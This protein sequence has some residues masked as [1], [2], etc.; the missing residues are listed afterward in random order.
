VTDILERVYERPWLA[1]YQ[2]AAL[3][4]PERYAVVEASTKSGKTVT[5]MA[6]LVE[7]AALAGMPGRNFWWIA[8]I[9]AQARIAYRR[10]RRGLPPGEVTSNESE[11]T[12][13]LPNGAVLWFKGAENPDS[14]FGEDV[15]A[16]VVDEASRVREE[17]WHA[18]RSTLTATRG[19][20]RL[21]GNV[22][23][24]RNWFYRLAR[25]AESGEPDYHHARI[26]AHDAAAAG[27]LAPD[28]VADAERALPAAVFRELYL[29]EPSD[30]EGN[31]FGI[32]AIRAC[33]TPLS[34]SRPACWGVDL[35]KA[36][37][38]TVAI[39]LDAERRV[40][41]LE[42]FQRSWQDTIRVL[43]D[44]LGAVPALVD[45]TGVGD[46]VLEA[47]QQG[48][49]TVQGF[50]FTG[51]SKQQLMEGLAVAI[52]QGRVAY[53]DGV[54]VRELESFEY[55]YTR[56]GVHYEAAEGAHDDAVCALALAVEAATRPVRRWVPL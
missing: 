5:A 6:W 54:I 55:R 14:L 47:L 22:K 37:D 44:L 18:V 39:A 8:P 28:E 50:K 51:P 48:R 56:T 16:A 49:R 40:C 17:A 36:Q 35:G 10:T 32:D 15:W 20:V 24:R 52:Q 33:V 45:S 46:P 34:S 23:G 3:F 4:C 29:A 11:L 27:I 41:R 43:R 2:T 53:P 7:R 19:P 21:I 42:R 30:D 9:Y 1:A 13:T 26:T 31:P 38:W 25:R 12:L